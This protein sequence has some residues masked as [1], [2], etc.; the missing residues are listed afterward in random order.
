MSLGKKIRRVIKPTHVVYDNDYCDF[1]DHNLDSSVE[2]KIHKRVLSSKEINCG[3]CQI[4]S[5]ENRSR[6]T[7][8]DFRNWKSQYRTRKGIVC[9]S[10][11]NPRNIRPGFYVNPNDLDKLSIPFNFD[12]SITK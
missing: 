2:R 1:Y 4:H 3:Y 10:R 9:Q 11:K 8:R 7:E 6:Q 12:W 5:D